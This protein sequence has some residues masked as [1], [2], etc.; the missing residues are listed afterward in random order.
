MRPIVDQL[1]DNGYFVFPTFNYSK[2]IP[3]RVS[4]DSWEMLVERGEADDVS[5]FYFVSGGKTGAALCPS[6]HDSHPL[7]VIDLELRLSDWRKS[8]R[9]LVPDEEPENAMGVVRSPSGGYHL[10]MRLPPDVDP[11]HIPPSFDFG[12]GVRGEVRCSGADP[13]FM[14]LPGSRALSASGTVESY[15]ELQALDL[16]RLPDAPWGLLRRLT[17]RKEHQAASEPAKGAKAMD[18]LLKLCC[19][20][21]VGADE[22]DLYEHV[23]NAGVIAGSLGPEAGAMDDLDE[24]LWGM[25][26]ETPL[27]PRQF[28]AQLNS[29]LKAGRAAMAQKGKSGGRP[30]VSD[31]R[32]ECI[33]LFGAIPWLLERRDS[34]GTTKETLLGVGG[35]AS[36]RH[37]ARAMRSIKAK[38]DIVPALTQMTGADHDAVSKSPIM[39]D[40]DY[41]RNLEF[42]LATTKRVEYI[43]ASPHEMF[44][45]VL[46][47]WAA[48]AAEKGRIVQEKSKRP[49]G[50]VPF[51][52]ERGEVAV[53]VIPPRQKERFM[54]QVGS[55][56]AVEELSKNHF[57]ERLLVG[58]NTAKNGPA[59]HCAID[60]L[61]ETTQSKIANAYH[62]KYKENLRFSS[63]LG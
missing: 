15:E 13:A 16:E 24:T 22:D 17:Q 5:D 25:M 43:G 58:H 56:S 12:T 4:G 51:I 62:A 23:R 18:G 1:I 38:G 55:V 21:A 29:G 6:K 9:E 60:K 63:D 10:W 36:R 53:L 52:H 39:T 34:T 57:F 61:H 47:A 3:E 7:L 20:A 31:M 28:R 45:Q 49:S 42:H 32:S 50:D 11:K 35:S 37:D 27:E 26:D 30:G 44:W 19:A 2:E 54:T 46:N 41:R 8:W 33:T 14:M 48:V 40:A 59:W